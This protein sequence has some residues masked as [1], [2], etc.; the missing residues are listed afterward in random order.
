MSPWWANLPDLSLPAPVVAPQLLGHILAREIAGGVYRG[1]IVEVEAYD[2]TDPACH[3]YRRQTPRN[4]AIFGAPST[5]YV[6]Q[7]YGIH[8]CVNLVCDRVNYCSAVLIRALSMFNY[9]PWVSHPDHRSSAGPAK[10]CKLLRID[11]SLNGKFLGQSTGLWLEP[12]PCGM[13]YPIYQTTRIG[14][15]KGTDIP[16]RWYLQGHPAVS[17]V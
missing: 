15:T 17:R 5:I 9:P 6:Y 7:I 4:Q 14:I 1:T 2:Q 8:F 12:N 3:G 13:A 16:W 10:L 11:R